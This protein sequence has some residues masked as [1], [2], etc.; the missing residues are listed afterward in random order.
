MG[1]KAVQQLRLHCHPKLR[2]GVGAWGL[3]GGEFK[4]QEKKKSRRVVI[5]CLPSQAGEHL[6]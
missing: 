5:G 3:Q 2:N 6:R 4:S 1:P